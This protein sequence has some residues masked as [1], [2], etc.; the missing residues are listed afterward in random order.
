LVLMD[1]QMPVMDGYTATRELRQRGVQVPIIACTAHAMA[2]DRERCLS[3]GCS[4]YVTKPID[5][6][7]LLARL[8][9]ALDAAAAS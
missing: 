5:R 6:E 1:M 2:E 9:A 7:V 4:D 8:A 3:A